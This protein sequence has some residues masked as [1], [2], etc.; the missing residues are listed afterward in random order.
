M[1]PFKNEQAI[2]VAPVYIINIKATTL[3]NMGI[4]NELSSKN[5]N[6]FSLLEQGLDQF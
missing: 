1:M 6:F 2:S 3:I 5:I 4:V